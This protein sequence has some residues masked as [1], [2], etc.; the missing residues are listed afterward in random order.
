MIDLILI[1]Y[2]IQLGWIQTLFQESVK[3]RKNMTMLLYFIL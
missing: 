2:S 1:Q 3:S